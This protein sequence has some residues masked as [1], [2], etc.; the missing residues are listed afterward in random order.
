MSLSLSLSWLAD[1]YKNLSLSLQHTTLVITWKLFDE[2]NFHAIGWN[3]IHTSLNGNQQQYLWPTMENTSTSFPRTARWIPVII[4]QTKTAE[5]VE[6][7]LFSLRQKTVEIVEFLLV[8]LSQ[9]IGFALWS[10]YICLDKKT[11][12]RRGV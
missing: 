6:F 11:S 9:P 4:R 12:C 5:T 3:S 10:F 2:V 1:S 8:L 7:L